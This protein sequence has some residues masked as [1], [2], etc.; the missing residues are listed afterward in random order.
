M[1]HDPESSPSPSARPAVPVSSPRSIRRPGGT[2]GGRLQAVVAARHSRDEGRIKPLDTFARES[3]LRL[4]GGSFLGI[5]VYK[6]TH[7]K[8]WQPNDFL[9]FRPH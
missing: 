5:A 2:E 8:V 3:L 4:T 1:C 6:D 9:R 7:D